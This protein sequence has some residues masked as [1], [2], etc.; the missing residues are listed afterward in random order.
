[1][2]YFFTISLYFK[3]VWGPLQMSLLCLEAIA[4][5]SQ[6]GVKQAGN[7]SETGSK[8]KK[9][10]RNESERKRKVRSDP[11]SSLVHLLERGMHYWARQYNNP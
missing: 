1:M 11:F 8:L 5:N 7:E 4:V 10:H 9:I 3:Q 6:N 2:A